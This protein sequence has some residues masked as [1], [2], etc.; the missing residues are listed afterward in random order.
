MFIVSWASSVR[1][2]V[3]LTTLVAGYETNLVSGQLQLWRAFA[4]PMG[5]PVQELPLYLHNVLR[6][7]IQGFQNIDMELTLHLVVIFQVAQGVFFSFSRGKMQSLK[8]ILT[9]ITDRVGLHRQIF[10]TTI[11]PIPCASGF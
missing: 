10:Q 8:N 9:A 2:H 11:L 6:A 5:V 7:S 4:R 1:G 3:P